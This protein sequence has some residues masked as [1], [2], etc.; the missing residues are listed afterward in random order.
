MGAEDGMTLGCGDMM[1][2]RDFKCKITFNFKCKI[3][4]HPNTVNKKKK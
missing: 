3:E 4:W 1:Q 2:Y